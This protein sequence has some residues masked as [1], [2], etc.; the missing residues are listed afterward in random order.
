MKHVK[1][2]WPMAA[3]LL[4]CGA[5]AKAESGSSYVVC[6]SNEKSGDIT[7]IDGATGKVINTLPVGKRPRGVHASP[8][9]AFLYV[10]LSGTPISGPP[11]LDAAGNPILAKGKGK[12]DDD[13]D[14]KNSDHS[15]D[16]IGVVDL[17][18]GKFLRKLPAGSDPEQFAVTTDGKRIYA[19]NEDVATASLMNVADGKVERIFPVKKEPEGV[20]LRPDG[21]F[22]YVTCET[23]GDIFVIDTSTYKVVSH[24]NVHPR[25]RSVA[26][27]PDGTRAFIPS[28]SV[29][30]L[31]LVDSVEHK[32][33]KTIKLPPGSRPMG[34][35][36]APDGKKL[37]VGTGRGGTVCVVDTASFT[38][39]NTI[40]V[41][42]RPWGVAVSPDGK[43]LYVA[44]GPSNDVSVV[45]LETEKELARIKAGEGPWGVVVVPK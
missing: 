5:I 42:A 19:S 3:A 22:V 12:A 29:E 2:V 36:M 21:K 13:D 37:Y 32:L 43:R 40:K 16:G 44:N 28:E 39:V 20:G 38:V 45:D 27:L 10:A 9:G 14:D 7:I 18:A 15:A 33:L 41:G 31:N 24:F 17:R 11:P 6:V 23:G 26:F 30:E 35:A 4:A 8:D 25:Q 1:F 34:T